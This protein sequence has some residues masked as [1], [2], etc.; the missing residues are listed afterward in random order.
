MRS[1]R[2]S[3]TVE[4]VDVVLVLESRREELGETEGL[5]A[6]SGIATFEGSTVASPRLK[7]KVYCCSPLTH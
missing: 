3:F 2:S 1:I 5:G 6:P 7:R 4:G